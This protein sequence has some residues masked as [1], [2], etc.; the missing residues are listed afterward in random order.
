MRISG[1]QTMLQPYKYTQTST[2]TTILV[3]LI[4]LLLLAVTI[5]NTTTCCFI[6]EVKS[7][8]TYGGHARERRTYT[9]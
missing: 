6:C 8:P 5:T 9:S 1:A 2:S 7:G 3:F 4:V